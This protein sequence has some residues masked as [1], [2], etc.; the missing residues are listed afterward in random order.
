MKH[1]HFLFL[2]ILLCVATNM[3]AQTYHP[4]PTQKAY[5]TVYEWD[6]INYVYDDKVY[7]VEGDT[8]V[9]G[10]LYT[11]VYKLDDYP[12]IYDTVRTLH[13][14]MR[15]DNDA[16]K[17]WFIRNYLGET[18]EKLGYDLSVAIGDTVSL[19]AF[20]YGDF[21][22]SLYFRVNLATSDT[23]QINDGSYRKQYL[24]FP[25]SNSSNLLQYIEGVTGVF[26]TFPNKLFYFDAFHQTF[27]VCID[28]NN[29]FIWPEGQDTT[30]CGF[31]YVGVSE[32]EEYKINCKPNPAN[33]YSSVEFPSIPDQSILSLY[34]LFGNRLLEINLL[35][36]SN[37]YIINLSL[38]PSGIYILELKT[39]N[40]TYKNKL[41]INH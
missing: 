16:K 21:G 9:N 32:L 8:T 27:T 18:T 2:A 13:C 17:I 12:T 38:F 34:N 5:W 36:G 19:P 3:V 24:F 23:V 40:F 29:N 15:Q 28:N 7:S 30:K 39:P 25:V 14:L 33:N 35:A 6:E 22:D 26:S 1:T 10:M 4:L 20:D 11:K 37:Q 41:I 31:N